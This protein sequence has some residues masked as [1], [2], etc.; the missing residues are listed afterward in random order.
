LTT[1]AGLSA[2]AV[3]ALSAPETR[4]ET[5]RNGILRMTRTIPL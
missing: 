1:I 4:T 3:A 2:E 5:R